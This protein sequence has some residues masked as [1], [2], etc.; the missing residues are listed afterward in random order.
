M[1]LASFAVQLLNG[2]AS[3]SSL[4]LV[5]AGLTLIFG[6]TRI[7]N[8]AHGSFFMLGAYVGWSAGHVLAAALPA[9]P[10]SFWLAVLAAGIAVA[11][12]GAVI[13]VLILRRIYAAPE[14][15]Q[16]TATFG[17]LLIAGDATLALWGAEDRLGPRVPGLSGTVP[18][19][20]YAVPSYELAL[21]AI[22]VAVFAL[23]TL[24][25][26]RTRF[27]VLVRAAAE[28]REIA[29][30]LGIDQAT[31]YTTVFA[32]GSF[33]AG[34][35]GALALPREPANLGMDLAVIADAFVVTVLGGLGSIPG[36]F[37]AALAIGVTKALCIAAGT[38]EVGG[39][40]LALP[41]LARV[42]EFIVMALVLLVRPTGLFGTQSTPAA[43]SISGHRRLEPPG[44]IAAWSALALAAGAALL[45]ALAGSYAAV[46]AT[47]ILVAALF[48]ASLQLLTGS[49]GMASFGHAAWFGIGAY[50]AAWM[51]LAGYPFALAV[52]AAPIAAAAVAAAFAG[53][54]SRVSG[55]HFA[56]LT[57]ALAQ[58]LWSGA[59]DWEPV[60]G[61]SNGLIGVWPPPALADPRHY[62]AL[63]LAICA[64]ALVALVA[65]AFTPYGYALRASRDAPLRARACGIA[66]GRRRREAIW[67]SAAFAGLAGALYAFSKGGVGPDSL[68]IPRSVDALVMLL[69]G[70][71]SA[72]FGPLAG[73][74]ALTWLQDTLARSTEYWHAA[75]GIAILVLVLVF[76][77]GIATLGNVARALRRSGAR[78]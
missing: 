77:D 73:A 56:M 58:I 69:L 28:N 17:V 33:L 38:I 65:V 11:A 1:S 52:I 54:S 68:A 44:R 16:L 14:L 76:P 39:I 25:L 35:A 20:G 21:I 63:V 30:A 22:A 4:F 12:L 43:Q 36:A 74:A 53:L 24:L 7:V 71:L 2:L 72:V 60:T 49:G 3:A 26:R 45:P 29:G 13:E 64:I 9:S 47:D 41:R 18:V 75:T 78:A 48:T 62:Y 23:L 31:L 59:L 55:I 19:L 10:L 57:L 34:A 37:I 32:L 46:L 61:G 27:G 8:F 15:L 5:A 40:A 67:L 42:I 50:A 70:G 6:V 51:S 66:V